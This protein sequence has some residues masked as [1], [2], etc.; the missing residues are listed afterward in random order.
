M[1][2][3]L[4]VT[5]GAPS[6]DI[7]LTLYLVGKTACLRRIEQAIVYINQNAKSE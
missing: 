1:P 7:D 2:L 3:R 4:A 6:P 5:G